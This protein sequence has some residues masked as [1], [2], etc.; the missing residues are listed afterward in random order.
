[1]NSCQA[2]L[3]KQDN[4][5]PINEALDRSEGRSVRCRNGVFWL[6]LCQP[7]LQVSN[8]FPAILGG[9][10]ERG[11]GRG[12]FLDLFS[13]LLPIPLSERNLTAAPLE[14]VYNLHLQLYV[15]DAFT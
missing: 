2:C 10:G 12:D 13:T 6:C 9:S 8:H 1:M 5:L 7:C 3:T 11:R 4:F 14:F 15:G